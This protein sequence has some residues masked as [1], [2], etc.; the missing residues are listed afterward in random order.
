MEDVAW[1]IMNKYLHRPDLSRVRE[2]KVAVNPGYQHFL[3]D[4]SDATWTGGTASTTFADSGVNYT[5]ST[6]PAISNYYNA[7]DVSSMAK[8]P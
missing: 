2:Q 1:D 6:S 4:S 8:A 3:M 5:I 7:A